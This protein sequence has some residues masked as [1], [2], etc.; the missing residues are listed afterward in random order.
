M[1]GAAPAAKGK[2]VEWRATSGMA[3]PIAWGLTGTH[4]PFST[5]AP[6]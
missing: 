1:T 4:D 5:T 2:R 3:A 6:A